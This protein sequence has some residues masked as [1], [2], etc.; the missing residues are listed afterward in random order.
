[1]EERVVGGFREASRKAETS[2]EDPNHFLFPVTDR[3]GFLEGKEI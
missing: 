3:S 2:L 1:V